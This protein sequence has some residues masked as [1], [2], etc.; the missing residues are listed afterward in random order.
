[1]TGIVP[2]RVLYNFLLSGNKR[3]EWTHAILLFV[4]TTKPGEWNNAIIDNDSD[5][6]LW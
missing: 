2:I 4:A 3:V 1:M 6:G 5:L